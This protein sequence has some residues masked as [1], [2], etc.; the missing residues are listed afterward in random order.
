MTIYSSAKVEIK[1]LA[2]ER[3]KYIKL[4]ERANRTK[5]E[6]DMRRYNLLTEISELYTSAF[7]TFN[8]HIH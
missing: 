4:H 3:K 6:V 5:Y 8:R 2:K 7:E 1:R